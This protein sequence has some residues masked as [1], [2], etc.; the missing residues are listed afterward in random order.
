MSAKDV[1]EEILIDHFKVNAISLLQICQNIKS[2][3]SIINVIAISSLY[4]HLSRIDRMPYV[5][6]KHGLNG[7]I[8]S[9]ALDFAPSLLVNSVSPGFVDT[10]MTR[11][12]N[13]PEKIEEIISKIPTGKLVD[14]QDIASIVKYLLL[15][16]KSITGQNIIVDGG[17]SC[18]GFEK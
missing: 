14:S 11:K 6:S 13:S 10:K 3:N 2:E 4:S 5:V 1:S 16:N 9:L 7:L 12:N 18:G 8:K 17:Y 15:E